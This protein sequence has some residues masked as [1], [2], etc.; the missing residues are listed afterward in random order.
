ME[1]YERVFAA[2]RPPE[3]SG[4]LEAAVFARLQAAR[5]ARARRQFFGGAGI[6]A[7]SVGALVP[8][9]QFL[10][11]EVAQSGFAEYLNLAFSPNVLIYWQSLSLALLESLPALSGAAVLASIFG[12]L[13]SIRNMIISSRAAHLNMRLG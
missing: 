5:Q 8:A 4:G 13:Y 12:L 1:Q 7:A 3:P 9:V 10:L 11:S 2:A 6:L